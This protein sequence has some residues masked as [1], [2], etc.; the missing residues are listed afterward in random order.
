MKVL[1]ATDGS[2]ASRA[3]EALVI[4]LARRDSVEIT[5]LSVSDFESLSRFG[6]TMRDEFLTQARDDA[7]QLATDSA[8]RLVQA[9]FVANVHGTLEG[10]P[11]RVIVR[12]VE[13][14]GY[15]LTL[16]GA[17][18]HGWLGRIL[19]GSTS[20][21]VLHES[22]SSV[23]V[24]HESPT[25]TKKFRILFAAD[26]SAGSAEAA[27]VLR[28]FADPARSE[29]TVLSVAEN[30]LVSMPIPFPTA[31]DALTEFRAA[32]LLTAERVTH[33]QVTFLT[34]AGFRAEGV[35]A[36]GSP[37][38]QILSEREAGEHNLLVVGSRG[39]GGFQRATSGSVSA[40]V[41]SHAPAALLGPKRTELERELTRSRLVL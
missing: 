22:P 8:D 28:S 17:G 26:D 36:Q 20:T 24:V 5:V 32:Q 29:I 12:A 25:K 10:E 14:E 19:L 6:Y 37:A 34:E 30:P 16:V 40:A 9:G 1:Y 11:G 21:Y 31:Q 7:Y 27:A 18:R 33:D 39:L 2:E 35:T 15:A 3:A 4:A 41:V 23:L 38:H 13:E